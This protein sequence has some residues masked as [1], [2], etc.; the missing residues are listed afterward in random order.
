MRRSLAFV[1]ACVALLSLPLSGWA[2]RTTGDIRG[3]VSDSTGAVLPGVTITLRG[4]NVAGAP[5][6]VTNESGIYRFPSVSPGI[7]SITAELS[8]F[9]TRTETGIQLSLGGT[10]QA[11]VQLSLSTQSE[12]IVVV[13]ESP[14]VD[15]TQRRWRPTTTASGWKTHPS[16]GSRSST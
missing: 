15:S 6:T 13:A 14:I 2:Q 8:G 11:N 4:E 9:T 7:Y 1:I 5:V 3:V 10:A 12:T 16:A